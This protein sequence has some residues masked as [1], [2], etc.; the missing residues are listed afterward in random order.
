MIKY[1]DSILTNIKV[2]KVD[3]FLF[4][5]IS[6]FVAS[7]IIVKADLIGSISIIILALITFW[8]SRYYKSLTAILYVA[9]CVRLVVIY[10]GNFLLI[11]PESLGDA[12]KYEVYAWEFSQNGFFSVI[13]QYPAGRSSYNISWILAFFYSF[14]GRSIVMAQS[15]SLFFGMG[16][17]L[18]AALI[19]NKIWSK[20]ISIKVGWIIALYPSLVLY[21]SLILR[22]AY[23]WFFLLVAIYGIICWSKDKSFKSIIIAFIGFG[24]ATFYHGGMII[25]GFI[26]LSI[27]LITSLIETIK[28]LNYLKISISSLALLILSSIIT[29]YLISSIDS[30]PKIGSI[31]GMFNFE[32]AL[33]EILNRN[34]N[35]AAFPE[36]TVPK[37]PIELIYKAP[38]RVLYFSF[39]PFIWDVT[40]LS[41]FFAMFDGIFFLMLFILIIKNIKYIWSDPILRTIFIILT[42]YFVIFGLSTGNFGTGIRHRT[43]FLI[44]SILL[45]APWIPEITFYKRQ[46]TINNKKL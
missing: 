7:L 33:E 10:F 34:I 24:G 19:A 14:T 38:I 26:F 22:E 12:G 45:V 40:K 16:S 30:I 21:S 44:V 41:H 3:F 15:L 36:W 42:S 4:S 1:I 32:Q 20:K 8:F 5:F 23:I 37:T 28:R 13:D 11:L 27:L 43:K 9:L 46:K 39:S 35:R 17:V 25:G 31:V 2:K 18:L 6:L 29:F